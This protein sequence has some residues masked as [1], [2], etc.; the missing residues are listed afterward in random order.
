MV[1]RS[2]RIAIFV[3]LAVAA[4]LFGSTLA[5]GSTGNSGNAASHAHVA[6]AVGRANIAGQETFVHVTVAGVSAESAEAGARA[7]LGRRGAVPVQSAEYTKNGTWKQF[8]DNDPGNDEVVLRY[9]SA[10]RPNG[11]A[12]YLS[13]IGG[14][15]P[16]NYSWND[17]AASSFSFTWGSNTNTCPSLVDE[18]PGSQEFNDANE[19]GWLDLGG[20]VNNSITLGVTWFNFRTRG[21]PRAAPQETDMVLNSNADINWDSGTGLWLDID[22]LTVAAHEFG[23]MLGLGHSSDGDALM[24]AG[25]QEARYPLLGSDDIAG[26]SALYPAADEG[27]GTTGNIPGYCKKHPERAGC[28]PS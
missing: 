24:Y 28:P 1:R 4:S 23:H 17:V 13:A 9:N 10:N 15:G 11:V 22:S 18:C 14:A 27:S 7:E 21:G 8:G 5:L 2:R 3:T 6:S 19:T 26:V 12:D 16:A 20:V 25:Y